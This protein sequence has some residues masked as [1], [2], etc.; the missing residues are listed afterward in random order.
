[1]KHEKLMTA[2]GNIEDK[3]IEE[4]KRDDDKVFYVVNKPKYSFTKRFILTL[5]PLA[6]CFVVCF[7]GM[8]AYADDYI[9][10]SINS[11]Y[12]RYLSPEEMA[13]AD[14]VVAQNGVDVYFEALSSDDMYKQYFAINKLVEFYNDS[15]IRKES[16]EKITPFLNHQEDKLVDA[17]SFAL[18]VLN[19]TFDDPRI[20]HMANGIILFTLFNDYSDYGS[21]NE[22]WMIKNDELSKVMSFDYPKMYINQIIPSPDERFFAVTTSSNKSSYVIVWD[23]VNGMTSPELIDSARIMVAKD[24]NYVFWQRSDYENYS[25]FNSI[26]WENSDCLKFHASL[27]YNGTEMVEQAVVRYYVNEK[28]MEYEVNK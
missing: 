27:S 23:L 26:E 20:I 5:L 12:L 6:A 11:F 1:M 9:Q 18:S 21:Y 8:K 2:I 19:K 3:Y 25:G 10:K 22:I 24:L 16:I 14:S 15:K 4:A 28:R 17:A 7:F 13:V